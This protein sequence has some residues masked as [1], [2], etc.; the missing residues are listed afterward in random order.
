MK[1]GVFVDEDPKL[2]RSVAED[3]GLDAL[4][5]HGSET[6]EFCA[7]FRKDYRIIK[8]FRIRSCSDLRKINDYDTDYYLLDTYKADAAGGTGEVFDW[9]ILRDFELLRPIILS[10]GLNASNVGAAIEE[11]VPCGVDVSSGV[12]KKPG[13]KDPELMKIFVERARKAE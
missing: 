10:G 12:E 5:F 9:K 3:T 4:Q 7:S 6:P 8:A 2:I 11:V 13:K 1:I